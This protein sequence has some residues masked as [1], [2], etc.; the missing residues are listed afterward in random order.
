MGRLK[1]SADNRLASMTPLLGQAFNSV[2]HI[3]EYTMYVLICSTTCVG[4]RPHAFSTH[5]NLIPANALMFV[6]WSYNIFVG[7]KS[8]L[9]INLGTKTTLHNSQILQA[10]GNNTRIIVSL[11]GENLWPTIGYSDIVS[12][13]DNVSYELSLT[14]AA[15]AASMLACLTRTWHHLFCKCRMMLPP[16][17][18]IKFLMGH[19][20]RSKIFLFLSHDPEK[21][22]ANIKYS[23]LLEARQDILD[24]TSTSILKSTVLK[25]HHIHYKLSLLH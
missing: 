18:G 16:W 23:Y 22:S 2:W 4:C 15:A 21:N 8:S 25:I 10:G 3:Q 17:R 14:A 19:T 1:S 7:G 5:F 11:Q 6:Q 9:M 20:K 24:P 13:A 12:S